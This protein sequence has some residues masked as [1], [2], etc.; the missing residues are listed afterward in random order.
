MG[1]TS[2]KDAQNQAFTI[3]PKDISEILKKRK[4]N[5]KK[6]SIMAYQVFYAIVDHLYGWGRD[7]AMASNSY[8]A[9]ATDIARSNIPKCLRELEE[10]GLILVDRSGGIN[11]VFTA[12]DD[13][14]YLR[15]N[16]G[17]IPQ[18]TGGCYSTDNKQKKELNK[19]KIN[20]QSDV[21]FKENFVF[22]SD[23]KS[24]SNKETVFKDEKGSIS[25]PSSEAPPR[26]RE[27]L[28]K[29]S[30]FGVNKNVSESLLR[31]YDLD[32]IEDQINWAP[33]RNGENKA[34]I[35]VSAIKGNWAMPLKAEQEI[36][37]SKS[38]KEKEEMRSQLEEALGKARKSQYIV[39]PS[40]LQYKIRSVYNHNGFIEVYDN[41]FTE[42]ISPSLVIKSD[43]INDHEQTIQMDRG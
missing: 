34:G 9:K 30:K 21:V 42:Y 41:G 17:V 7:G 35:I 15:D 23:L 39:L 20:K 16:R 11:W 25:P 18:I 29:L 36:E 2:R 8:L 14:C 27:I 5:G 33:Y 13:G 4:F 24:Q 43:F 28:E 22:N 1:Y 12:T 19:E 6:I 26:N 32:L 10:L 3:V 31:S 38:K 40:G 37:Q